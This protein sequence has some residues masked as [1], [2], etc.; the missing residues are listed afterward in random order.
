MNKTAFFVASFAS[1][2]PLLEFSPAAHSSPTRA[3]PPT[4]QM[5]NGWT[6]AGARHV[7]SG[8]ETTS[9]RQYRRVRPS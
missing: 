7:M 3:R 2:V 5:V 1:R 8:L 4:P 9:A 6:C